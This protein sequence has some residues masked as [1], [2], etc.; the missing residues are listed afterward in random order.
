[1]AVLDIL[2][3]VLFPGFLG[4]NDAIALADV[5]FF[6]DLGDQ[7]TTVVKG[8]LE[9]LL[10][11]RQL[12][13][14]GAWVAVL[15]PAESSVADLELTSDQPHELD[16]CGDDV[17]TAVLVLEGRALEEE[18]V[19]QGDLTT[20]PFAL[21][22]ASFATGVGVP[23]KTLPDE[24]ADLLELLH[25]RACFTSDENCQNLSV[26]HDVCYPVTVLPAEGVTTSSKARR[27]SISQDAAICRAIISSMYDSTPLTPIAMPLWK[28]PP[29]C[30]VSPSWNNWGCCC[31]ARQLI[32][33]RNAS[34]AL[35]S[36]I[37]S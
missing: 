25:G 36:A 20:S 35:A 22:E 28:M 21:V 27:Q 33:S 6:D 18:T 14:T 7:A 19:D 24:G 4:D 16:A 2:L 34:R 31:A 30:L 1:M 13:R 9:A 3:L 10:L 17:S 29:R 12:G 15:E 26:W 8:L 37:S 32:L 11:A 23:F 5:T